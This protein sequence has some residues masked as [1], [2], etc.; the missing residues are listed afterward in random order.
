M[1]IYKG[2]INAES[3]YRGDVLLDRIYKG[4]SLVFESGAV[5]EET[6]TPPLTTQHKTKGQYLID[7]KIYGNSI[8][9]GTPS[10]S[11][12]IEAQSVGEKTKNLVPV[13]SEFSFRASLTLD[14]LLESGDYTF[15]W[16]NWST[17][18]TNSQ[19]SVDFIFTDDT[20][21]NLFFYPRI[22]SYRNVSLAKDLKA[23]KIYS[24]TT[25]GN[26][27]QITATFTNLMMEEGTYTSDFDYVPYGYKIPISAQGSS[28]LGT[29]DIYLFAP[30]RKVGDLADYIDFSLGKVI[31]N[32]NEITFD[33]T[34]NWQ[35]LSGNRVYLEITGKK[36]TT[37]VLSNA[38][39][40]GDGIDPGVSGRSNNNS[41]VFRD[42]VNM[43][44]VENW[45]TYVAAQY[46]NLTPISLCYQLATPIEDNI[47]L[48]NLPT[49]NN[50]Y[51]IYSFGTTIQPSSMYIKY[52]GSR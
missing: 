9:S 23:I 40:Y 13:Q 52:K 11:N 31:R 42:S 5:Y 1:P 32:I 19:F 18:A 48:P 8:Q 12:H 39:P 47:T 50:D 3:A 7:Y 44:S 22:N 14:L 46:N 2:T 20:T 16:S 27:S 29:Y 41:V 34:E 17:S 36:Y 30:L 10:P 33:G 28:T 4:S 37:D 49:A 35:N 26:S 45:K 38:Y 21:Q 25:A 24:N 43:T 6:G 15:S 51:T